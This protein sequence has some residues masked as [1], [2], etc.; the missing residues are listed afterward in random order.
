MRS[1]R[2]ARAVACTAALTMSIF[3]CGDLRISLG[4][5][6]LDGGIDAPIDQAADVADSGDDDGAPPIKQ[7]PHGT[8]FLSAKLVPGFE[9]TDVWSA[10]L[11]PDEKTVYVSIPQK[12]AT[13]FDFDLYSAGRTET[14]EPFGVPQKL[15]ISTVTDDYWPTVSPDGKVMFFESGIRPDGAT[16]SSRIWY[17]S[18]EN[19]P[20]NFNAVLLDYFASVPE[21]VTEGVPYLLPNKSKL[22]WA[23]IGREGKTTLDI[24]AANV[25]TAGAVVTPFKLD[26][27]TSNDDSYPVVTDDDLELFFGHDLPTEGDDIYVSVRKP[28]ETQFPPPARVEGPIN[29]LQDREWSSWISPDSCRLYFIRRSGTDD[30][31]RL[32]VAERAKP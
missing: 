26:V 7:C 6:L 28:A 8:P 22:Y 2:V 13:A 18:R 32:Y 4:E 15:S 30:T 5:G 21:T 19:I 9:T 11:S 1:L 12:P 17:A 20:G 3:A 31:A 27:S 25:T 24:W 10:R 16:S 23:S 29:T 14:D